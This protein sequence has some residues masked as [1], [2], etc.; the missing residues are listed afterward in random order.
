MIFGACDLVNTSLTDYFL[1]NSEIVQATGFT[2]KTEHALKDGAILIPPGETTLI[3]IVLANPRKLGHIEEIVGTPEG[4]SISLRQSSVTELEMTIEGAEEGDDYELTLAMQS[5]DGLRDFPAYPLRVQCVS[6]ETKLQDFAINGT[7]L[8]SFDPEQE[9][10]EVNVPYSQ[11]TVVFAGTTAHSGATI[12]IYAGTGDSGQLLAAGTHR[13]ELTQALAVGDNNFYVRIIALSLSEQGYAVTVYRASASETGIEDFY[14]AINGKRYGCGPGVEPESGSILDNA[15]RITLPYG[16]DTGA[17][18]A[19]ARYIGDTIN[20]DPGAARSYAAPVSYTVT[21]REGRPRTYTVTVTMAPNPA[22]TITAF[23]ILIPANVAG[24]IDEGAKT[25]AVTVPYGTDLTAMTASASHSG[26]SISPDPATA[27]S[28]ASPVT[29]TVTAADGTTGTYTVTVT[30]ADNADNAITAFSILTPAPAA[31][32]I[33]QGAKT[34]AVTVPYGTDL[35][36]MTASATHSGASISPD[37]ATARSY[38]GPVAYTVA[39]ADGS[40]ETY[41]VTVG[42]AKI[43][44]VTAVNGDLLSPGFIKDGSDISGAIAAAI[45]SVAGTDSLGTAITLAAADYS[46]EPLVPATAGGKVTATLKVPAGK[47][48][49]GSEKI[50]T[51]DVYINNNA[52]A[53][54]EFYFTIDS[55]HYGAGT[56]TVARSG[57]IDE[58]AKTATVTV[59]YGTSLAGLTPTI[60]VS[61]G[62][63]SSPATAQDFTSPVTYTVTA[64][65]GTARQSYAVTVYVAKIASVTTVNGKLLSP[66]FI[67]DDSDISGDIAAAITSVTGTDGLGTAITLAAADY[68]VEPLIPASAGGNVTATLKVPADKTSTGADVTKT[69]AVYIKDN[70]K[71][72]TAFSILTPANVAGTINE[73]AKTIT[74]TVPYGTALTNMTAS[75]S[76]DGASISPDP[77]TARDYTTP[78]AYKVTAADGSEETYAVTV[79]VDSGITIGGITVAE[80]TGLTFSKVPTTSVTV[81]TPITINISGGVT[82]TA[83][84]VDINGPVTPTSPPGATFKFNAPGTPGFYNINVIATVDGIDYS[85]SFGLIVD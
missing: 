21:A 74:V 82:P 58:A 57:N 30:V 33:D 47:T 60:K 27:R 34:I 75:A 37:P 7:T 38:A 52:S 28:Y 59:P 63:T 12:E 31:G 51:F 69:F 71:A 20:P 8:P 32:T 13:V 39:L 18:S 19:T 55:K 77:A 78:V 48:S 66:G 5:A 67:K 15:I 4:K 84:H 1:D 40:S 43:A 44:S 61:T 10:L 25:I 45:T 76:Y 56:G 11:S 72:I 50:K 41:T 70:A 3:D 22:A 35:T 68:S 85:G 6:F 29:Y 23:S 53:I 2:V 49:D 14:F 65:D 46:V 62:A 36:A 80:L 17:L 83:W 54:T 64:E 42:A 24:T 9:A 26:A 73:D 81:N 16:T 79:N